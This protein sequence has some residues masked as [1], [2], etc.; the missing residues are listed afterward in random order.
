MK[1][2]ITCEEYERKIQD[3]SPEQKKQ[4]QSMRDRREDKLR[5]QRNVM[6]R[7]TM[8]FLGVSIPLC[9][10][11]GYCHLMRTAIASACI[12]TFMLFIA[13][14]KITRQM[15]DVIYKYP[16]VADKSDKIDP[17]TRIHEE[18]CIKFWWIPFLITVG[19]CLLAVFH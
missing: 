8:T 19:S 2:Q 13:Q 5:D 9:A 14:R 7:V 10:K 18:I 6:F 11:E 4:L 12:T 16:L 1:T 17:P 3:L 15:G